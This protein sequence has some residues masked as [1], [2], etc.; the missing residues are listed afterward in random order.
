MLTFGLAGFKLALLAE[1]RWPISNRIGNRS[2]GDFPSRFSENAILAIAACGVDAATGRRSAVHLL[3]NAAY[4]GHTAINE[5]QF[6]TLLA[7][8]FVVADI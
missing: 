1:S 4:W 7:A 3:R 8:M 5:R 6:W 2:A